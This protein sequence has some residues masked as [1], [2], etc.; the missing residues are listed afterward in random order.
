MSDEASVETG[1]KQAKDHYESLRPRLTQQG[2]VNHE[3]DGLLQQE[4]EE[5]CARIRNEANPGEVNSGD[6]HGQ[7]IEIDGST[8]SAKQEGAFLNA[9]SLAQLQD[10][11]ASAP[12]AETEP[13]SDPGGDV[14]GHIDTIRVRE[15][16]PTTQPL[17]KR[18]CLMPPSAA[19]DDDPLLEDDD[20]S[21]HHSEHAKKMR[22]RPEA[23]SLKPEVKADTKAPEPPEPKPNWNSVF[24]ILILKNKINEG[25]PP[26][27]EVEALKALKAKAARMR[28]L[29]AEAKAKKTKAK[30]KKAEVKAKGW[31]AK[32]YSEVDYEWAARVRILLAEAK[33]KKAEPKAKCLYMM[34]SGLVV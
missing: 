13:P 33:A 10:V 16:L 30:A 31:T 15:G 23:E 3:V 6:E 4:L 7:V 8:V 21:V 17:A 19:M 32:V 12:A 28:I 2:Q 34:R 24:R 9:E 5:E 14:E 20:V 25:E 11:Q 18:R 29:L 26:L 1:I 22:S 27:S